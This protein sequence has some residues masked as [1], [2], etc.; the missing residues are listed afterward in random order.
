MF[1]HIN[2]IILYLYTY[3]ELNKNFQN[4]KYMREFFH[5]FKYMNEV[6]RVCDQS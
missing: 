1:I 2:T 6:Y 5:T 3:N 4:A